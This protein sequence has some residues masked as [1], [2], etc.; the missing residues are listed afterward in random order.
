MFDWIAMAEYYI[1][2]QMVLQKDLTKHNY[3]QDFHNQKA[4]CG[5]TK[6]SWFLYPHQMA[7]YKITLNT[8]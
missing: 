3:I 7:N 6:Y 5:V 2:S 4:I 1:P 8:S